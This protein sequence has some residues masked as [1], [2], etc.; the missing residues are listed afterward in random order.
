[1]DAVQK[2]KKR[3]KCCNKIRIEF[4][5]HILRAYLAVNES[6]KSWCVLSHG[7]QA[8]KRFVP[9]MYTSD[10]KW[11]N[12]RVRVNVEG[13]VR[14]NKHWVKSLYPQAWC[15][16]RFILK[17][18]VRLTME[19]KRNLICGL[20]VYL[21]ASN[22]FSHIWMCSCVCVRWTSAW[23][24]CSKTWWVHVKIKVEQFIKQFLLIEFEGLKKSASFPLSCCSWQF[25]WF[26]Q[27]TFA[28][29]NVVFHELPFFHSFLEPADYQWINVNLE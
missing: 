22:Q 11:E 26:C 23:S 12:E 20:E 16:D 8:Q 3:S 27:Q 5:K 19:H 24:M 14:H 25:L 6:N 7:T 29:Q 10:T 9:E 13:S 21:N 15:I 1:M 2:D 4:N 28:F 18:W 17:N